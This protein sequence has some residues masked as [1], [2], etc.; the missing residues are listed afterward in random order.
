MK[1][2]SFTVI[3]LAMT[4]LFISPTLTSAQ[5]LGPIKLAE[6]QDENIISKVIHTSYITITRE[7][8]PTR[9]AVIKGFSEPIF[10]G[11]HGG[12]KEFYGAEPKKEYPATL[13][14]II[15]GIGG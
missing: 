2:V 9:K 8:G 4:V 5:D 12:L 7:E 15:A 11:L 13:D 10:Y 1:K 14:H 3:L 6:L